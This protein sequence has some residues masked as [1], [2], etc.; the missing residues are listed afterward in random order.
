[1]DISRITLSQHGCLPDPD[2]EN[3]AGYV[4]MPH[5]S[6]N[7]NDNNDNSIYNYNY[8]HTAQHDSGSDANNIDEKISELDYVD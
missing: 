6:Y 8:D 5:K 4:G 1:M 7:I 3:D 2:S